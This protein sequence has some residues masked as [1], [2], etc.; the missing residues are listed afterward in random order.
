MR[1]DQTL[2]GSSGNGGTSAVILD[3]AGLDR[4]ELVLS[5]AA[6]PADILDQITTAV[7]QVS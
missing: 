7:D 3:E 6:E 1:S 2:A 4:L 5:G